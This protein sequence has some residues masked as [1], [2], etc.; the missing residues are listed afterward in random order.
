MSQA[1]KAIGYVI[2]VLGILMLAYAFIDG[3]S[4]GYMGD[5]A[6]VNTTTGKCVKYGWGSVSLSAVLGWFLIL[7]GPALIYGEAPEV[8]KAKVKEGGG[9]A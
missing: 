2:L 9:E 8:I 3:W 5:C 6:Q 7:V 4:K 1:V